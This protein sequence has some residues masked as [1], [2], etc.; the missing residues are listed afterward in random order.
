MKRSET[1]VKD[2]H[3]WINV[4][5]LYKQGI[6]IKQIA[7]RMNM[8]KNT[9][10]KLLNQDEAPKYNR[11]ITRTKID[12][13]KDKIKN[14]YLE[15][16]F[17]GTR[18]YEELRKTDYTGGINPIYR[19]LRQL[20]Y[21]KRQVPLKATSRFE[22]PTGEQAQ[23]DW[24]SY[25]I[26][27]G[28][29]I[30]KII[31]FTMILSYSRKKA[32]V[33]SLLEDSNAIYEAIQELYKDLGGVT[34]EL[35]IDNP[36]SLVIENL[37]NA[38]PKF[39]IDALHL[40]THIGTE[41]NPCVPSRAQTKGKIE[42]PYQYID[43]HFIK[44]NSFRNMTELNKSGKEFMQ[45]WNE[46]T[47]GTTKKIPNRAYEEERKYLLPLPAKRFIKMELERRKVS[48][49]SLISVQGKK[50]SVPVQYV[51]KEVQFRIVY[52]YKI[53]IYDMSMRLI[54]DYDISDCTNL[55]TCIDED[56]APLIS[57]APKSI[58]E[59]KRQ[60]R[61]AFKNGEQFLD[62]SARIL[63]QPVYHAREVL[64]LREL[65]TTESLDKILSYCIENSI[66][67]IDEIKEVLKT[68]YIEI[69]LDGSPAVTKILS[70]E[71]NFARDLSYYEAG[72]GQN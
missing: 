24:S 56:Y 8:S 64:K 4:K 71:K 10:K 3:D 32:I 19:Y 18:I 57:K 22:T 12:Q 67:E 45:N 35:I 41:L 11:R 53:E 15:E 28:N 33:F 66:Y 72:G 30:K 49:D 29:E 65:Y 43:E 48:L 16:G 9:V 40:A 7:Q 70:K 55:I 26:V 54:R 62:A 23:F 17:I 20:E 52:G 5:R 39:N 68:K 38:E 14:W 1:G 46:K 69:V 61:T 25:Q 51:G 59:V 37:K 6:K 36:K 31:C 27:V 34:L 60:F 2:L 42:K 58:P 50:Y 63:S 44:G 47:H 21:E 13:Y